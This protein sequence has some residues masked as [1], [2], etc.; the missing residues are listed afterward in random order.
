MSIGFADNEKAKENDSNYADI[1]ERINEKLREHFKL[2]FL[3]RLD[4]V[5]V[6]RPL[7]KEAL[8]KIIDLELN[9]VEKRL[10]NKDIGLK[11]SLKVKRM[12]S[13]KGFDITFGARPL[14]RLIQSKILDELSLKIIEG[15]I[16][17]GDRILIDIGAENKVVLSVK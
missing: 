16:K 13:E 1:K 2:E 12:L 5:V 3:N 11:I 8:E 10:K 17:D 15:K 14:K 9:K 6:F 7:S 4:E